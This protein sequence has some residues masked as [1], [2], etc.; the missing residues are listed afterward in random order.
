MRPALRYK[1]PAQDAADRERAHLRGIYGTAGVEPET[2]LLMFVGSMEQSEVKTAMIEKIEDTAGFEKLREEWNELLQA[3]ASNCLF[4][5]WEWLH[6]WWK[7]LSED[8]TLFIVTVRSGQ[9]LTA[10]APLTLRPPRLTRLVPFRSLEFLGSGSIGSDYLDVIIRV[11]KEEDACQAMAEYLRHGKHM[12][13]LT[14]LERRSCLAEKLA[15][16]LE[17]R[18]W[19]L[20]E[21]KTNVCPFINLSGHSWESYLATFNHKRRHNFQRT[22]GLL[23]KQFNV[24]FEQVR[25]EE[26]RREALPL[27]ISLHNLRWRN[28]AFSE[29][30]YKPD[31]VSFHDELS[32]LAL[33]QGWLRLFTLWIDSRPAA[34]LYG[35]RYR[36]RF[37]FYQS[38]FDPAYSQHSVGLV[39]LMLCIKSTIEEGVEEFDFLHGD[40]PYK[41][42]WA[43]A[44]RE[45]GRLELY[46]P[47]ARGSLYKATLEVS[48]ATRKMARRVLGDPLADRIAA[49]GVQAAFL[50]FLV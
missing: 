7:H 39:L 19:R 12:L 3:S 13:E 42:H 18:G 20:S 24:R 31:L 37:Y 6:T 48:R 45:L 35:F 2:A 21:A 27:L 49:P 25:S 41:L 50:M 11:G 17:R 34:A 44:A 1:S 10:I 14:Q 47:G 36:Q 8:R 4:L 30:F 40:E 28:R 9:E 16:E 5:T 23:T 15:A 43:R 29:A 33:E 26:Q 46:P 22:L 38:G 32:H